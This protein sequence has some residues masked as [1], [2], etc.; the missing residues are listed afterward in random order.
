MPRRDA[1]AGRWLERL[2]PRHCVLCGQ[3]GDGALLCAPCHA[4]LPR[5]GPSCRACALPLPPTSGDLCGHCLRSPP[6]W[7]QAVAALDYRFP[8]D[9]LVCR[10]KF[11]RDLC[12]GALLGSE[13]LDAVR[14]SGQ[15]LP[16]AIV[17][18]PLHRVRHF[19]RTFNQAELLARR[20]GRA[21][22]IPVHGHLLQRSRATRAQSGLDAEGRRRNVRG[23]F[24]VA[25]PGWAI[26]H[27][28]LVDDVLTTGVTLAECSRA[29]KRAGA[30]RVSVWVAARAAI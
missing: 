25:Q 29:L 17:P 3:P 19:A 12:A 20:L 8:A 2:L 5:P 27:L 9:R 16:A 15:D 1:P 11:N 14:R 22:D 24:R 23:A 30:T 6:G 13:L 21:L 26:G 18:V 28:A 4:E 7:D 10:L